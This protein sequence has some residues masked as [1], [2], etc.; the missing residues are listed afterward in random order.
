MKLSEFAEKEI[1]NVKNGEMIGYITDFEIDA[2]TGKIFFIYVIKSGE[3]FS[4]KTCDTV[5]IPWSSICKIGKDAI[6]VDFS[7]KK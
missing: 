6:L 1:V 5:E 4:L 3:I 7:P 2:C